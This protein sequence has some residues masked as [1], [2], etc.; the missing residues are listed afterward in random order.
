MPIPAAAQERVEAASA[1]AARV[2]AAQRDQIGLRAGDLDSL[3]SSGHAARTV[4]A[5]V[6]SLDLGSLHAKI[7]AV[8]HAAVRPAIDPAILVALWLWAI[9]DGVGSARELDRLC[10]RD[11]AYR[12]ICGGV[13]VNYHT[14]GEFPTR[15]L[16]WFDAQ[17]TRTS[18]AR[19][20]SARA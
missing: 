20:C 6:Q 10:E 1:G 17:P 8:E 9:I 12:W 14:L 15:H 3:L 13:G 7:K 19:A 2:M 16:E 18:S 5:F 4:W 11:A